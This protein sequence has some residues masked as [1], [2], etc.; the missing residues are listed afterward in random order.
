MTARA[1]QATP[2]AFFRNS[3][4]RCKKGPS[5]LVFWRD[6]RKLDT[7][8]PAQLARDCQISITETRVV[9]T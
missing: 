7:I 9:P 8:R 6:S 4:N 5:L 2:S 1:E 3:T